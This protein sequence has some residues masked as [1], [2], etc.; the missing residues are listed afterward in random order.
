VLRSLSGPQNWLRSADLQY[1]SATRGNVWPDRHATPVDAAPKPAPLPLA[2]VLLNW[3]TPEMTAATAKQCLGVGYTLGDFGLF[4]VDNASD[5]GSA[6]FL[7]RELPDAVVIEAGANLGFAAGVNL[8][9]TAAME[10]GFG[11]VCLLNNDAEPT[12]E[13]FEAIANVLLDDP[14]CGGVGVTIRRASDGALE[15]LGGGRLNR[16][17]GTQTE[18]LS[19]DQRLDF[20]TGTCMTLRS[21]ALADV[22]LFDTSFFMYWEDV[23]LSMRLKAAGWHLGVAADAVVHHVGQS[24]V[25]ALSPIAKRYFLESMIRYFKKHSR[26]WIVPVGARLLRA[27]AARVIHADARGVR[28]IVETMRREGGRRSRS[29]QPGGRVAAPATS[30]GRVW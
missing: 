29:A 14:R 4:V 11:A 30:P 7:R 21:A 23:D 22:G 18:R 20:I 17:I 27:F 24:T 16:V 6:A 8:G 9:I 25:G 2:V 26:Y 13:C 1:V 28:L 19:P 12:A 3:K 5:D 15:A 10:G